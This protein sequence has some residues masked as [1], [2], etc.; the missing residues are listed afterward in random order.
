MHNKI[1]HFLFSRHEGRD[2]EELQVMDEPRQDQLVNADDASEWQP[3]LLKQTPVHR[4][5]QILRYVS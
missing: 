2:S 4:D 3:W 1:P 5:A